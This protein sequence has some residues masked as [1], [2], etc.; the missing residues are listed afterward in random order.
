MVPEQ[1][2][3][4]RGYYAFK[5]RSEY[6]DEWD[7]INSIDT[8]D[9]EQKEQAAAEV[10]HYLAC[11]YLPTWRKRIQRVDVVNGSFIFIH[12]DIEG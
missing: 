12:A 4:M 7:V 5:C 3:A 6:V 11:G 8:Y 10:A 9:D 1:I 2:R